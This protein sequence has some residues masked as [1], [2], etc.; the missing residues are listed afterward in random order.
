M[1]EDNH[2]KTP[3][4]WSAPGFQPGTYRMRVSRV[5][6]EP[7]RSVTYLFI[8]FLFFLI[9]FLHFLRKIYYRMGLGVRVCVRACVSVCLSVCVCQCVCVCVCVYS[10]GPPLTIFIPV[11]RLIRNVGYI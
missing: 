7:P 5:T 9:L 8:Y 11:M 2:E 4:G 6:T 3:S 1:F 10:F